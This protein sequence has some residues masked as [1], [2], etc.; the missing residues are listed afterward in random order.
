MRAKRLILLA[1]SISLVALWGCSSSMDSAKNDTV[2][3]DLQEQIAAAGFVGADRCIDCHEGFSWSAEI[4]Q[5]FLDG[6]HVIHSDNINAESED[7]CLSCH[8]PIGDGVLIEG[9]IN[10]ADVPDEGLAAVTCENCHGS[11]AVIDGEGGHW[12]IGPMPSPLPGPDVCGQCHDSQWESIPEATGHLLYHPEGNGIYSDYEDSPHAESGD[13]NETRCVKCHTD[14]GGRLYK[15]VHTAEQLYAHVLPIDGEVSPIQCRTCHDAHTPGELLLGESELEL[16]FS[17]QEFDASPEYATCTNCHQ[18]HNAQIFTDEELLQSTIGDDN[19]GPNGD[20]IYHGKR[21]DRVIANTHFDDPA[22]PAFIEGYTMD[23][24]GERPCRDCHNVHAADTT[25]N[26]QWAESSHAGEILIHKEDAATTDRS[27][28]VRRTYQDVYNVRTAGVDGN[29]YA[30]P[31]HNWDDTEEEGE[32]QRCHTATGVKN[33]LNDPYGY[34]LDGS[35]NDFSHLVDWDAEGGSGQ[36]ELL[37]CW[38]CHED[39]VGDLRNAGKPLPLYDRND[40]NFATIPDVGNSVVCVGCHG[41]RANGEYLRNTAASSRSSSGRVHHRPAAGTLFSELTHTGYEFDLDGDGNTA[42]HYVNAGHIHDSIGLFSDD[43]GPC[44]SCHMPNADHHYAVVEKNASGTITSITSQSLCN[45]CH[46]TAMNA[47]ALQQLSDRYQD[48]L[49]LLSDVATLSA[50]QT[51]YVP[52][53]FDS[54]TFLRG[55]GDTVAGQNDYGAWQNYEYLDDDP[56]AFTHN[57]TYARR[58]V[59]DSLDWLDNGALNGTITIPAAYS[60]ARAW[61]NAN[62]SGVATRP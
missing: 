44:V 32:C 35:D 59:F 51:N 55:R 6:K 56:G 36:N 9:Y 8:D 7:I 13:R 21:W 39:N 31:D 33:F 41:G 49:K 17:G 30:W 24:E 1:A 45:S 48:A 23:P 18:P 2:G 16:E 27:D 34:A 25:I 15:D 20:L 3:D 46:G 29:D 57:S 42:E 22:T 40:E 54:S 38:G 60:K 52:A 19:D 14:E 58:I 62:S 61:L 11:G 50:G 43:E 47:A 5:D 53:D 12:G 28:P 37:Y 26:N 4:V 10:P